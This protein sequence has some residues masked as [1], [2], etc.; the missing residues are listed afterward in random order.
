MNTLYGGDNLAILRR[1]IPDNPIALVY[2]DPP[3]KT[4][5][6]HNTFFIQRRGSKSLSRIK[7]FNDTW[8]WDRRAADAYREIVEVA[9][10]NVSRVMKALRLLVGD[11][12]LLAYLAMMAPRLVELHRVLRPGGALYLH[13]DCA[14]SHYLKVLLDAVFAPE[15]FRNEIIWT[16]QGIGRKRRIQKFPVDTQVLLYYTKAGDHVFNEQTRIERIPKEFKRGCF[17]LPRGYR[18]DTLGRVYWTSPRGDYTDQSIGRL[19]AEGRVSVTQKG[20]VRVKY[21]VDEEETTI[22]VRRAVTNSWHDIPDTLRTGGERLG[23]PTQKPEA[24]LE[25]IIRTSSNEGDTVLDPFCGSGT[26]LVVAQR[27][28]RHWIGIDTSPLA[29]RL[30]EQRLRKTFGDHL[31][32]TVCRGTRLRDNP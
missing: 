20:K 13:C 22:C 8:R 1:E 29:V 32:Y 5:Q 4:N 27:L 11:G 12:S 9:A 14:A 25:R 19:K 30:A 16:M 26:A 18:R 10:E 6:S 28:H 31:V 17:V 2:L 24:L 7:V 3:F 15:N 23:Y 21:F